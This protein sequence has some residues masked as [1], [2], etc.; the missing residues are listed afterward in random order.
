MDE[1]LHRLEALLGP[2][3]VLTGEDA[4]TRGRGL[5]QR[6]DRRWRHRAAA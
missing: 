3:G 1:L 6:S 4:V 2:G 5:A